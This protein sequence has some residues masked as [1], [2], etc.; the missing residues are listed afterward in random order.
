MSRSLGLGVLAFVS[1][2]SACSDDGDG[3][4]GSGASTG[5]GA[6]DPGGVTFHKDIEPLLQKSCLGCHRVGQIGG[7]SLEKYESAKALSA[8]IVDKTSSRAM[9]P[10]LAQQTE[11]CPQTWPWKD[12]LRLTDDEIALLKAW[13]DA[14]AP[15]GNPADAP[16]PFTPPELGLPNAAAELPSPAPFT[17]SGDQDQFICFIYD[18][19]LTEDRYLDGVHVVPGNEKV[20]HHALVFRADRADA[21]AESGGAM[22]FPCFGAG[23]GTLVHGWVPGMRPL[24]LPNNVGIEMTAS[25]V[26]VVQMHYHPSPTGPEEDATTIQVRYAPSAPLWLYEVALIGNA[27]NQAEGLLPGPNDNGPPEFRIPANAQGHTE[28]IAVEIPDT[29]SFSV[30]I[31]AIA[32]HMHYVGVDELVT[33][34]RAGAAGSECGLHTPRWDFNWQMFYQVDRPIAELPTLT[35]GD[36][37]RLKCVYDNSMANPFVVKALAEQGLSAPQ[38]VLLGEQTLDEMCLVGLGYLVPNL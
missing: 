34:E 4:T 8:A 35:G 18:P 15:E 26:F 25:D 23:G 36:I 38:D 29:G 7:F 32:N 13:H 33:I 2:L 10:F 22:Q 14:G 16:P 11:Q 3:S 28:E 20:A 1:V 9:P 6:S 21:L 24:E 27:S 31:L 17:V 30:P 19:A 37:V 5:A 12:D